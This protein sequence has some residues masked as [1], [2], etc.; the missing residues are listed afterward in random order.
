[1]LNCIGL[2]VIIHNLCMLLTNEMFLNEVW[3][4]KLYKSIMSKLRSC[5]F[6]RPYAHIT[7]TFVLP[8]AANFPIKTPNDVMSSW[9]ELCHLILC[10]D[11]P[12]SMLYMLLPSICNHFAA[13]LFPGTQDPDHRTLPDNFP[14]DV[15]ITNC[16]A[17]CFLLM[18]LCT[19]KGLSG[20]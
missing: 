15:P 17:I 7:H 1:M 3:E 11:W 10:S 12:D 16:I 8:V 18:L 13:P 20:F 14:N 2:H 9:G 19:L 4:Y 6:C 5:H